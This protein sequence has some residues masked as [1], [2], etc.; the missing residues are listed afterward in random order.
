MNPEPE[1]VPVPVQRFPQYENLNRAKPV[2]PDKDIKIYGGDANEDNAVR[3]YDGHNAA[4]AAHEPPQIELPGMNAADA[5]AV[6][7][8]LSEQQGSRRTLRG[9]LLKNP[10]LTSILNAPDEVKLNT[11]NNPGAVMGAGSAPGAV[12]ALGAASAL[13]ADLAEEAESDTFADVLS[14]FDRKDGFGDAE[15]DG[16]GSHKTERL[17]KALFGSSTP[18]VSPL[19]NPDARRQ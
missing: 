14:S 7:Q 8:T 9:E 11:D 2:L 13:T 15:G 10:Y 17:M 4:R 3:V 19:L 5:G 18:L 12:S 16:A 1:A 6:A